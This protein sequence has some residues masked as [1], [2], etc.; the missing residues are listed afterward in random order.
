MKAKSALV[1]SISTAFIITAAL[2]SGY[3]FIPW[4]FSLHNKA[5]LAFYHFVST[6]SWAVYFSWAS[7]AGLV[8][9]LFANIVYCHHRQQLDLHKGELSMA[10]TI[11]LFIAYL[12]APGIFIFMT[13][14]IGVGVVYVFAIYVL[15]KSWSVRLPKGSDVMRSIDR[16][17]D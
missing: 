17:I 10:F 6:S 3:F 14:I 16:R 9:T 7:L 1:K 11:N 2:F 12:L 13:S 4:I 5:L 15:L 8:F